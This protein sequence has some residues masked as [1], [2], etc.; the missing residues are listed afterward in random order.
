MSH[1][2]QPT[3][4]PAAQ[5]YE[6]H[7]PWLLEWLRRRLGCRHDAADLAHDTFVRVLAG[8][9]TEPIHEPRA[10]LT[11]L[12]QRTL[13][14]FWR[15]RE[16][17]RA[18]LD[19]LESLPQ[20]CA[21]SEEQRA[22][23]VEALMQIDR[24]RFEA[25]HRTDPR[26]AAAWD[27]VTG[28][29][30]ST[31]APLGEGASSRAAGAALLA[32][33][34][35]RRAL[36]NALMLALAAGGLAAL[37]DR[38]TPLRT[39][40]A[41]LRTG[42]GERRAY[43]LPDGSVVTL[44]ARSAVDLQFDDRARVLRLREGAVYVR[45]AADAARPFIVASPDG[46]VQ[47]LGTVFGVARDARGS[48][49]CVI[50]HSVEIR[51]AGQRRTLAAGEGARFGAHGIG[52]PD[53]ALAETAAWQDGMLVVRDQP[54]GEVVA[55]LRPYRRGFLRISPEAARLRV[56]GAFPLDDTDRVLESLRQ[57]LP[58]EVATLGGWL[59]SIDLRA[60]AAKK[61]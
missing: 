35:R 30:D 48:V 52:A 14:T 57:T 42:T 27:L 49:A 13:Y 8:R 10:F 59:V 31:F 36:R 22:L 56:L 28:A 33:T 19:S 12:A 26:H 40:A 18:Y 54:L 60:D 17:E 45:V 58:I 21:P 51:A 1:P 55:A 16:L 20:A 2:A 50:E 44:N 3:P 15:R 24:A 38:Q 29:L 7:H 9:P 43:P 32:P 25:W 46:E 53:A 11:T 41:D 39:L 5:L 23:V 37:V 34:S 47:A 61:K 6:A 4:H